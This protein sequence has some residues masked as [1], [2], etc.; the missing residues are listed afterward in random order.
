ML[1][2]SDNELIFTSFF[3]I[4][5]RRFVYIYCWVLARVDS[6]L[7][8]TV[9]PFVDCSVNCWDCIKMNENKSEGSYVCLQVKVSLTT[10]DI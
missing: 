7:S 9:V 1:V 6:V 3:N 8:F 5:A 4:I 2:Q 10:H